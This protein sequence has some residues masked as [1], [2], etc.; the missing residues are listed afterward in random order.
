MPIMEVRRYSFWGR[1][2]VLSCESHSIRVR[3]EF[4]WSKAFAIVTGLQDGGLEGRAGVVVVL[5]SLAG[6]SSMK[7]ST[8][9]KTEDSYFNGSGKF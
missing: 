8:A 7:V 9:Q 2:S 3:P 1:N 5:G 4:R 6:L